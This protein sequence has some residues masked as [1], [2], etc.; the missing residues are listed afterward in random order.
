MAGRYTRAYPRRET[1]S[2][3]FLTAQTPPS[4]TMYILVVEAKKTLLLPLPRLR[5][6]VKYCLARYHPLPRASDNC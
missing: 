1:D 6:E 5:R 2:S 3:T 4:S